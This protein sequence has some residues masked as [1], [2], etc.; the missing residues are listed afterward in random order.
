MDFKSERRAKHIRG[1][2]GG[3]FLLSRWLQC[4]VM[5]RIV[6]RRRIWGFLARWR[7]ARGFGGIVLDIFGAFLRE[8]R[9]E[10]G[11]LGE[12]VVGDHGFWIRQC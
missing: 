12:G 7:N 6:G 10:S 11:G 8:M 2:D 3:Y 5:R 4:V 1:E 9:F